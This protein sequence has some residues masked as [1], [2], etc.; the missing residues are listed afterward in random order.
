MFYN[1]LTSA[2]PRRWLKKV[3]Q[4]Y[5]QKY[6]KMDPNILV[7][8]NSVL[9]ELQ[10]LRCKHF[11]Q[12]LI[13]DKQQPVTSC[14]RWE[15]LFPM[16]DFDWKSVFKMPYVVAR[17]T[18]LQSFQYKLINRYLACR[19]N[20]HK[21]NKA[22][23]PLCQDCTE[24]DTIDHHLYNCQKLQPFWEDLFSWLFEVYGLRINMSTLDI[25]LGISNN[26]ND[27]LMNVFNYCCLLAKDFIYNRKI[28]FT[29]IV[30]KEYQ[31][32]LL[33]R[34]EIEKYL[35]TTQNK[36]KDF[37]IMWEDIFNNCTID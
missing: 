14:A 33:N 13:L 10:D 36:L 21:W 18:Y 4:V 24:V 15:G 20:L 9:K 11:Y 35:A 28:N 12:I 22:P 34:L 17:E 25:L 27:K 19:S 30:F 26:N 23:S 5:T 29:A 3:T 37:Y 8:N 31:M 2:V 1:S 32:Q 7:Y 6:K 16:S